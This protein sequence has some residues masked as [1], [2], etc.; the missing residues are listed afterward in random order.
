MAKRWGPGR[1][2]AIFVL[3]LLITG[4]ALTAHYALHVRDR[5]EKCW[6]EAPPPPDPSYMEG[7]SHIRSEATWF[8][9][10]LRCEYHGAETKIVTTANWPLTIITGASMGVAVACFA[11]LASPRGREKRTQ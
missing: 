9:L 10:G 3:A 1:V 8:P 4:L 11:S 6:R 5:S 2:A 7:T